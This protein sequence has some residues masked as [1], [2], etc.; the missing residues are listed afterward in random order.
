MQALTEAAG[1]VIPPKLS[2]RPLSPAIGAEVLGIDLSQPLDSTTI[3]AIRAAWHEHAVLLFRNQTISEDDQ[4]RYGGYFGTLTNMSGYA[5]VP[6]GF[7]QKHHPAVIF[8]SNIREDG[9]LIGTLPDG[10][11]YFHSDR[12]Y[13]PDPP[14]ATML[15][16]MEIPRVGGDTLFANMYAA[17][18]ALPQAI[19]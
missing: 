16:A 6:K 14:I 19:K 15:Y 17:Y 1:N 2:K 18:D 13:T 9:S 7:K 3:E 5:E 12:A 10:E 8:S 11:V 4:A